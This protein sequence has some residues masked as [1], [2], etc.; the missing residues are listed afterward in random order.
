MNICKHSK[1]ITQLRPLRPAKIIDGCRSLRECIL[2]TTRDRKD[3]GAHCA[4]QGIEPDDPLLGTQCDRGICPHQRTLIFLRQ[5][6]NPHAFGIHA[7]QSFEWKSSLTQQ[8]EREVEAR[9][10]C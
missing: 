3:Y 8:C 6:Q 7:R 1:R 5:N 9:H 2:F 4:E 10:T